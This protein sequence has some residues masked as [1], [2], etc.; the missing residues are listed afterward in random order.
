MKYIFTFFTLICCTAIYALQAYLGIYVNDPTSD[1]FKKADINYGI[2]V[3]SVMPGSPADVYGLKEKDIIYNINDIQIRNEADLHRF[4]THVSPDE[5][6]KVK[7]VRNKEH[8]T[9]QIQLRIREELYKELYIYNYVQNPWLFIGI[10]VEQISA[11]L[12]TLLN[13]ETGMVIL[14][15]RDNSIASL[16]DLE[17][18]DIIISIN[19]L[20]TYSIETLTEAMNIGLQNQPMSFYIWRNS[21]RLTKLIDLS[22]SL[23]ENFNKNEVVILGPD[24]VNSELYSYSREMINRIL[25]KPKSEIESDIERLEQ[26]IFMLRQRILIDN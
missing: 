2:E 25:E 1:D 26:E 9:M 20:P 14:N 10:D 8:L 3:D 4:M 19:A 21:Q 5:I 17:A 22:N 16:Q 15:V 24:V 12:A 7:V 6:I 23:N 11:Q 18:G 13:L